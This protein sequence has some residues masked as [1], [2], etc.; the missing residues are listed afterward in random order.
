MKWHR[1]WALVIR[2]IQ[3]FP[4]DFNKW[5]STIYWPFLDIVVLGFTGA[6]LGGSTNSLENQHVLITGV[7]LWQVVCRANFGVS[8]NLLEE[9]WAHNITNLFSTPLTIYEWVAATV[10]EGLIMLLFIFFFCSGIAYWLYNFNILSIGWFLAPLLTVL[11]ISGLAIG[12]LGAAALIKKGSKLQS[13]VWMIGWLF[14][15]V[16]G[17]FYPITVLPNWLQ[18]VARA[19]PLHYA[20]ESM[21]VVVKTGTTPYMLLTK[22]LLLSLVYFVLGLAFFVIMF[23][24]SKNSGLARIVD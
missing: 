1:I 8:I 18:H 9:V 10:I 5:S 7:V 19:F 20:F 14:A 6:W 24:K 11:F 22:S 23:H 12:L 21:R 17:A 4:T 13:L 15:P 2:H 3:Q 16:S